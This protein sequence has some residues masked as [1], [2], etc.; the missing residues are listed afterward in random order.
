MSI[1]WEHLKEQGNEEFKKENY[2]Q[3]I[4]HYSEAISI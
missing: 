2:S 4:N 1:T 3:A